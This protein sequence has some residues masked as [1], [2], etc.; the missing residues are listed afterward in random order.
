MRGERPHPGQATCDIA[1]A[2]T[3]VER[4]HRRLRIVS[5]PMLRIVSTAFGS[6][7]LL[8]GGFA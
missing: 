3:R 2:P 8:D 6:A 4:H 1:P 7:T 5:A